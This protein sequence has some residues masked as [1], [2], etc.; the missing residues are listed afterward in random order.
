[1]NGDDLVKELVG[2]I[3]RLRKMDLD[4]RAELKTLFS[5][6]G[7]ATPPESALVQ[8]ALHAGKEFG[9]SPH[10]TGLVGRAASG[11]NYFYLKAGMQVISWGVGTL[12]CG[13]H[14]PDEYIRI[15]DI[16]TMTKAHAMLM[17]TLLGV[18][19]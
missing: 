2:T 10:L 11:D 12:D 5:H 7:W 14:Q 6:E 4:F 3:D 13:F 19:A 17:G 16:L 8:A 9:I 18:E 1:M 15:A